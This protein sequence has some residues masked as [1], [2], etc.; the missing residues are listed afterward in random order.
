MPAGCT[1]VQSAVRWRAAESTFSALSDLFLIFPTFF[2]IVF[3]IIFKPHLC[4][5]PQTRT[6]MFFQSFC[7]QTWSALTVFTPRGGSAHALFALCDTEGTYAWWTRSAI[8]EPL[9][10]VPSN[11]WCSRTCWGRRRM[12]RTIH[13]PGKG[14]RYR[15]LSSH[16]HELVF[17]HILMVSHC[18]II[19]GF[20]VAF[21]DD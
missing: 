4:R 12:D 6:W 15:E 14:G 8:P 5:T 17:S 7:L 21:I 16:L 9:A 18:L 2:L 1:F 3:F 19:C 10:P 20:D 11:P 13:R